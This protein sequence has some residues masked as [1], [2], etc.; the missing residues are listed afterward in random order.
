MAG[1]TRGGGFSRPLSVGAV[2][3]GCRGW[4]PPP[5][6]AQLRFL[7]PPPPPAV[8]CARCTHDPPHDDS[9]GEHI[10]GRVDS[11][12]C[13]RTIIL[14]LEF[15][16]LFIRLTPIIM[17]T[18][19]EASIRAP[20]AKHW[21]QQVAQGQIGLFRAHQRAC[22]LF[23]GLCS[24]HATLR[25]TPG[26]PAAS[27]P[28]LALQARGTWVCHAARSALISIQYSFALRLPLR[29][30]AHLS[31]SPPEPSGGQARGGGQGRGTSEGVRE[32]VSTVRRQASESNEEHNSM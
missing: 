18:S 3:C 30:D 16:L 29:H 14:L 19:T 20:A 7:R 21:R 31:A 5:T 6:L 8:P 24:V 15:F 17:K 27:T 10:H 12:T 32:G 23:N 28:A 1:P 25:E 11:G 26:L 4:P 2:S 13:S 22:C 9:K